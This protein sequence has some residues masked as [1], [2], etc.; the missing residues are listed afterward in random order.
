L[1][2]RAN[3]F[4]THIVF[5]LVVKEKVESILYNGLVCLGPEGDVAGDYR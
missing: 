1:A 2:K 4:Q 5:G 3:D